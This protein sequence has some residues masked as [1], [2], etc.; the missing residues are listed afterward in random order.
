MPQS[1]KKRQGTRFQ[2][3][4]WLLDDLCEHEGFD[5]AVLIG[6]EGL[7]LAYSETEGG[8]PEQLA[9]V[10][11]LFRRSAEQLQ[12]HLSWPELDEVRIV[13]KGNMNLI[14]QIF[15][16]NDEPMILG[17]VLSKRRP[18]REATNQAIRFIRLAWE[19]KKSP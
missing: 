6:P 2:T 4:N 5:L 7:P 8:D 13:T 16:L 14:G 1:P 11:D 19:S 10:T 9:A 15:T 17:L 3:I 12:D 18:Y